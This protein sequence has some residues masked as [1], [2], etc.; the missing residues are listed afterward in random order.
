L[1]YWI[2]ISAESQKSLDY[3]LRRNLKLE[4]L[5]KSI[6]LLSQFQSRSQLTY[7]RSEDLIR[8]AELWAWCRKQ[9]AATTE[10]K[11]IDI[12]A[13]LIS[14]ALS[15]KESFEKVVIL[16]IDIGD[17][18]VFCDFGIELWDWKNALADCD[19]RKVDFL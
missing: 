1:Y 10:N 6:N 12:D 16:T 18:S 4:G 5:D 9:G 3:E 15:Q 13:I 14:Q 2:H 19:S 17:L 7:L 11:G 8:A